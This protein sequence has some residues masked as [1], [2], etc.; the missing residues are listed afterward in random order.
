LIV[1]ESG[2]QF[3]PFD[4]PIAVFVHQLE[5]FEK[6][7]FVLVGVELGGDEGIDHCLELIF[8]LNCK[9]LT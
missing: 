7:L 1:L 9:L 5:D 6:V 8:E 2:D 4:D 3:V